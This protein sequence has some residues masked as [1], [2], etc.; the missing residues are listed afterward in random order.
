MEHVFVGCSG[1]YYRE[2][3]DSFYPKDLAAKDWFAYYAKRFN[4]LEIN[5]SFY[6]LPTLT[7][8]KRWYEQ[9]P[10]NFVFSMKVPRSITH[11]SKFVGTAGELRSFYD[12]IRGSLGEKL[13]AVLFQLPGTVYFDLKLLENIIQQLDVSFT[14]V[15]EFRH[16]SWWRPEVY[17]ILKN[18]QVTF[19]S[20]SHP[21]LPSDAIATSNTSYLR[22]HG[23]PHLYYSRYSVEV[24]ATWATKVQQ[25]QPEKIFAYFNNTAAMEALGNARYFREL[26]V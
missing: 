19:C 8:L 15:I 12:L 18:A 3:K 25:N 11:F 14:N 9:S 23:V 20:V 2:W 10:T 17:E 1:F 13:G 16:A 22:F 4:T 21:T 6:R 24:L 5:A 26:L 7:M